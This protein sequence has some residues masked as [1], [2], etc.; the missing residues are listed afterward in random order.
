MRQ[1]LPPRPAQTL[2]SLPPHTPLPKVP[3]PHLPHGLGMDKVV[4]TPDGGVVVIL[5]LQVD[6][7]VGQVVALRHS[8]LLPDLVTLLLSALGSKIKVA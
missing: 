7:Q 4:I 3:L 1:T 2:P 6:I 5:P 8:K